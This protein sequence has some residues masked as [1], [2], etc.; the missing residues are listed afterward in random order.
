[1]EFINLNNVVADYFDNRELYLEIRM[2]NPSICQIKDNEYL[3]SFRSDYPIVSDEITK[4]EHKRCGENNTYHE[5]GTWMDGYT[6]FIIFNIETYT[7]LEYI[8]FIKSTDARLL[9]VDENNCIS[10][11]H[12]GIMGNIIH[13]VH[14]INLTTNDISLVFEFNTKYDK[15]FI[16]KLL[17][18]SN[19]LLI[20]LYNNKIKHLIDGNYTTVNIND[21]PP[22]YDKISGSSSLNNDNNICLTHTKFDLT[23]DL[24][25]VS[26]ENKIIFY[27]YQDFNSRLFACIK[28]C[29]INPLCEVPNRNIL[30]IALME[31]YDERTILEGSQIP[32]DKTDLLY[33]TLIYHHLIDNNIKM[34]TEILL[35]HYWSYFFSENHPYGKMLYTF[36]F[37]KLND[38][39]D[40]IIQISP[41]LFINH[42]N[43]TGIIFPCGLSSD[44]KNHIIT[45][46]NNKYH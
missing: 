21:Y 34:V 42:H 45:M 40:K 33:D 24:G 20:D 19:I 32:E 7:M 14:N 17:S 43:F 26:F 25:V 5:I 41:P 9:K 15:N 38:A 16:P 23:E 1:M 27:Y 29:P 11:S 18:G 37:T 31:N 6:N 46:G 28:R 35:K 3:L 4:H 36:M 39:C 30:R 8:G 13:Y 2:Y 22:P 44:E 10:Y 12:S